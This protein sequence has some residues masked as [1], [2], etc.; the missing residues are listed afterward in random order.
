[1]AFKKPTVNK[2]EASLESLSIYLRSTKKFGKTT[3]FRDTIIEEYGDPSKGLLI[4]CG[5]EIGYKL[6]D[7]L[8]TT[9]VLNYD[10]L[11]ELVDWLIE[12]KGTEHDI[13]VVAFDT[14]D[15]LA[16]IADKKTISI[17]NKE[18]PN[19]RVKSIKAAMGGFTAGE[20]YSANDIIKPMITKLQLAGFGVWA[21]AHTKYKTIKEKGSLE[22]DGYMQLTSNLGA[23][24]ESAFGDIFDVTLTG[25]IDR[26]FD[27]VEKD[28]KTKKYTTDIVRKLYF[29]ETPLIDAG[30]RFAYGAVPEYVVFDKPNMGAEFLRVIKE[31]IKNSASGA[32]IPQE[33]LVK[34]EAPKPTKTAEPEETDDINDLF[35]DD[36]DEV[37]A[38]VEETEVEELTAESDDVDDIF[39]DDDD[40]PAEAEQTLTKEDKVKLVREKATANADI[41]KLVREKL[42]EKGCKLSDLSDS[43]LDELIKL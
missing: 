37:E 25:V 20:K 41:K 36:A 13:R 38:T 10:E 16:L 33:N 2:I 32:I 14:A 21:I 19:K 26:Q 29:R 40:E 28:G 24:Y 34:S 42:N 1:M 7:N 6:L 3:L 22:E 11:A 27:K 43:D 15:E 35:D 5:N 17:S 31:G 30:G 12:T 4:G 9:Q 23:D 18:N 39:A 8:N